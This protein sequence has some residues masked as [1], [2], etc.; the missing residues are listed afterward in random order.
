MQRSLG[1]IELVSI[2]IG[3]QAGDA[4]LKAA[5]VS[6]VT[7]QPVCAG[8]Y[9]VIVT[10]EV[11]AVNASV[12]AGREA[13]GMKLINEIVIPNVHDQVPQAINGCTDVD[14]MGAVGAVETY[15]L[16]S[17]IIAA[18]EAVKAAQ[19]TLIEIR[20]GRGLGGKS[21]ITLAGEVAAVESAIRTVQGLSEVEGLVSD[22][23]V[24][25]SLHPEM[26]RALL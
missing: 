1:M 19:V 4:M 14:E 24:I 9:I 23:V 3:I 15:S 18:D 5:E 7:A 20:L 21:Y 17:A 6:L 26:A 2:P 22:C 8:K 13:A 12:A 11:S 25:P 16:C 10:G